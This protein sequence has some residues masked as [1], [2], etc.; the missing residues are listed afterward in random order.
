MRVGTEGGWGGERW[1]ADEKG[2]GRKKIEKKRVRRVE[3][4]G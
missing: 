2:S 1:G 4:G 3:G